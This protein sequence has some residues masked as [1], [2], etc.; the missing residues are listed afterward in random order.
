MTTSVK[1]LPF[2]VFTNPE[3]SR[4]VRIDFAISIR[5]CEFY[6]KETLKDSHSYNSLFLF[7]DYSVEVKNNLYL[8]N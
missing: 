4:F 7:Q 5:S 6:I 8:K 2:P 3:S 1:E